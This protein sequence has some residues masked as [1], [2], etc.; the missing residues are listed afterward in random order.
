MTYSHATSASSAPAQDDGTAR[1]LDAV[2]DQLVDGQVETLLA[3]ERSAAAVRTRT[4][5]LVAAAEGPLLQVNGLLTDLQSAAVVL[6][7]SATRAA[8]TL[9]STVSDTLATTTQQL[10]Q[11]SRDAAA[12]VDDE[13]ARAEAALVATARTTVD[14]VMAAAALP[15]REIDAQLSHLRDAA[16]ALDETATRA[17][18]SVSQALAGSVAAAAAQLAAEA[19]AAI[20]RVQEQAEEAERSLAV[21]VLRAADELSERVE[22][23]LDRATT[24]GEASAAALRH[25]IDA[26]R[27]DLEL[28]QQDLHDDAALAGQ[29]VRAA[30]EQG[31]H[32]LVQAGQTLLAQLDAQQVAAAA[33]LDRWEKRDARRDTRVESRVEAF[34]SRTEASLASLTAQLAAASEQLIRLQE[35]QEGRRADEFARVLDDVLGRA[36]LRTRKVRKRVVEVLHEE[37]APGGVTEP[38]PPPAAPSAPSGDAA[39]TASAP[40]AKSARKAAPAERPSAKKV[41]RARRSVP[42]TPEDP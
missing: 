4:D 9:A 33:L 16:G 24:H 1:L 5:E 13:V 10:E 42:T 20:A 12:R 32:A 41:A 28:A 35:E 21:A 39:A 3:L 17:A 19:T 36:G 8:A 15:L 6:G 25:V 22:A 40:A 7:E 29:D 38:P 37:R 26:G 11:R 18:D 2:R 34:V 30:T 27:S 31:V 14:E 23:A